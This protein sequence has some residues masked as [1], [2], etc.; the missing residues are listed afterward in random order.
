[1]GIINTTP[2]SFYAASRN[3]NLEETLRTANQMV[4]QGVDIF[5]IGGYSTRP[6]AEDISTEEEINRVI[7]I[8]KTLKEHFPSIPI[9]LDT[10]RPIVAEK[11]IEVGANIIN[12]ISGGSE[13]MYKLAAQS[14]TPYILMHMRGTPQTMSQLNQYQNLV[15]DVIQE[16][17]AKLETIYKCGVHDIILDPGFGFAKNPQQNFKLLQ[18]LEYFTT[19][20]HPLLAGLSRKSMIYKTLNKTAKDALYG[21]ISL[22]TI[23]LMK[24]AQFLRVHDV[25]AAKDTIRMVEA[26]FPRVEQQ[27]L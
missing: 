6:G 8:I 12:D 9:S 24:G 22:N 1:M 11:G 10:F 25:E 7:P 17:S 21:T 13:S 20:N 27:S 5:D 23:A 19:L 16:L 14:N 18:E 15:G 26:T 4:Q 2:D 3:Q